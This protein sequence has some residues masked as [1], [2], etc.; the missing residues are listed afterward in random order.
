MFSIQVCLLDPT[1]LLNYV[2]THKHMRNHIILLQYLVSYHHVHYLMLKYPSMVSHLYHGYFKI[3]PLYTLYFVGF[4]L[5]IYKYFHLTF[6]KLMRWWSFGY[7]SDLIWV[8]LILTIIT[9][10]ES[11]V[12]INTFHCRFTRNSQ[13]AAT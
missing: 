9:R 2:R 1:V 5:N 6:V 11:K 3:L 13:Y 7:I 10:V 12:S 4:L 8:L